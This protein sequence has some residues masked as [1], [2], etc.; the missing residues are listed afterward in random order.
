MF[1][2]IK[3][4]KIVLIS[5]QAVKWLSADEFFLKPWYYVI[6]DG[7]MRP[8]KEWDTEIIAI[9]PTPSQEEID[10]YNKRNDE[11]TKI[12]NELSTHNILYYKYDEKWNTIELSEEEKISLDKQKEDIE[13]KNEEMINKHFTTDK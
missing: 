4:S 11:I 9:S 3:D 1:V 7:I 12:Q 13:K 10:F 5:E 8:A 2:Y 6:D